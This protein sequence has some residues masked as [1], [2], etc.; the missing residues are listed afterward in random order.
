[1]TKFNLKNIIGKKNDST[2]LLT[3]VFQQF[4]AD[5]FIEDAEGKILFG[6]EKKTPLFQCPVTLDDEL[7]GWVKGDEKANIIAHLLT[8]LSQKE[9][10]KKK[11]GSEVLN[12]YQEVNLIFNFSDK[13]AQTIEPSAI[14]R[15][16]LDEVSNLIKSDTGVVVLWDEKSK[17]LKVIAASG[18]LF[19]DEKKINEKRSL[20]LNIVLS[21]QSEIIGDITTLAKAEI[22]LPQVKTVLYAALKVNHRV[23]GAIILARHELIQYTAADLKM[24]TTLTLQSSSAI[25]SALLYEKN[26]REA[27]EREEAMRKVYDAAGKF[28]PFEFIRSLEKEFIT[29]VR[30]GDHVEKI[31]TVLF[32]DIRDYTTLAEQMTPEENFH[33]VCSLNESIGPMIKKYNGFANQYLGDSI[34]A[35]FPG[36]AADALNAAIDMQKKVQ[37]FNHD[38]KLKNQLP[39]KI[40]IGMHT[41]TLIMGITGDMERMDAATISDT[42]NTASRIESLTKYY[43]VSILLSDASLAQVKNTEDFRLRP[44]GKVQVKGKKAPVGIF[45]CFSGNSEEEISK[46]ENTL[47]AFNNGMKQ[48]LDKSFSDAID[49][50]TNVIN[51]H[52]EDHTAEFF[53]EKATRYIQYGVPENWA[54]I[55][56]MM[57]K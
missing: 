39:I 46:K 56:E 49:S 57:S 55:E 42:V 29:D 45:E 9:S 25:E 38:R 22:I 21:G 26:I 5:V 12:L 17:S 18:E 52:P 19:F 23:M 14:A 30:L 27:K 35:I 36:S 24:L 6:N 33:F 11:L 4:N 16:T 41:G 51:S 10:E 34:M 32:T 3:S 48:Y 53:I 1:M 28:V 54:G 7:L 2:A 13:L 50:F 8:H 15:I 40:G 20:L 43:Q 47:A 31:V 37:E 44:L